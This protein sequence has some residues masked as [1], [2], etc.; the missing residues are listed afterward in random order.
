[1]IKLG[2]LEVG[3]NLPDL[4]PEYGTFAEWCIAFLSQA[5]RD[6]DFRIFEVYRGKLP[7]SVESCQ[8]YLIT[9]SASSVYDADPWLEGLGQFVMD[10]A[11]SVPIVGICFGHQL[12]HQLYGGTVEKSEKGWGIGIHD[13]VVHERRSWMTPAANALSLVASH[14][15]QV[16][17]PAPN[18]CTLAGSAFCPVAMSEFGDNVMSIQ[19]HPEMTR[20]LAKEVFEMRC[21]E[22][23]HDVTEAAMASMNNPIDDGIA[24]EWIM[25]HLEERVNR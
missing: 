24:A 6:I 4:V 9:G 14:S 19:P 17:R 2:I 16:T 5:S 25:R 13:Y 12:L 15:D 3:K 23:G 21:D 7:N 1:M 11:Q 8:A 20:A 10:V 22:Q 18:S